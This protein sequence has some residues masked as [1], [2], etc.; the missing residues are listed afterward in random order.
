MASQT[1]KI[2]KN[3]L[4][5][6][7]RAT[8]P[9]TEPFDEEAEVV[10]IDGDIAW[11]HFAGGVPETPVKMTIDCKKGDMVQVHVAS[12]GAFLVGNATAPPTDDTTAK[13]A[14]DVAVIADKQAKEASAK[15]EQAGRIAGNTNQYFWHTETG[16]DTGAHITEVPKDDFLANPS[17]GGGN[18]LARSNGIAVRD[19]MTEL[20]QFGESSTI[21]VADGS[22][23]YLYEDY[24]SLQMIDKEGSTYF[25][26]SDLRDSTGYAEVT[27]SS[28][29]WFGNEVKTT[30]RIES[31]NGYAPT[32]LVNGIAQQYTITGVNTITLTN[33]TTEETAIII[34]KTKSASAKAYTLGFRD[35]DG[36]V[37]ALS[38]AEGYYS[39]AS[40]I[41]S[42]A[43]GKSTKS[44]GYASHAEGISTEASGQSAHAEGSNTIASGQSA[45]A[46][47]LR[48][49]ALF[50][51]QTALGAYN[52]AD[53]PANLGYGS[54]FVVIIGNGSSVAR[55]NALT[56]DWGGNV[57]MAL[58]TTASSGTTDGD[59]YSAINTLGW[60]S[61]VII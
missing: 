28:T 2:E 55:S 32:V 1:D 23:S 25:Y 42:H 52:I 6:V 50:N 33:A 3:L 41:Y 5:A 18:L 60:A 11:V 37:G 26:V 58:D 7:K 16:T 8:E 12:D 22:Q 61:D 59:L 57:Q 46:Q 20:A 54:H 29:I 31:P 34:Y 14:K 24:H 4:E 13:E 19:G 36:L 51:C 47:G 30:L 10:R 53:T 38:L 21:G 40:G 48:T 56:V 49:I 17:N 45:H 27:E 39:T 9:K 35:P 44:S 43:E 15:A